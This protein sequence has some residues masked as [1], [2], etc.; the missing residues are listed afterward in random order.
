MTTLQNADRIPLWIEV[1]L[2]Q[3]VRRGFLLKRTAPRG[4][5]WLKQRTAELIYWFHAC[6]RLHAAIDPTWVPDERGLPIHAP[7]PAGVQD[8]IIG[9]MSPKS[10]KDPKLRAQYERNIKEHSAKI[11][12]NSEQRQARELAESFFPTAEKYIIEAYSHSPVNMSELDTRLKD[13]I[14]D[15][16]MRTRI[17]EAVW[18]KTGGMDPP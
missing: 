5:E 14:A 16:E 2:V 1:E 13:Y 18:M 10:I 4:P 11:Q 7:V 17:L 6:K 3:R 8:A 9:G 12:R 15:E